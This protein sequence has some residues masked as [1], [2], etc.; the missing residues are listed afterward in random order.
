MWAPKSSRSLGTS[1]GTRSRPFSYV[2]SRGDPLPPV[3]L[4]GIWLEPSVHLGH[5]R[6]VAVPALPRDELEWS[7]GARHPNRPV[8]P[9]IR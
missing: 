2:A 4:F 6:D 9:R 8:V 3:A 7:A 1:L 5:H